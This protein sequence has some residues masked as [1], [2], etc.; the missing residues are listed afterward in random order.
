MTV[1][2]RGLDTGFLPE[3]EVRAIFQSMLTRQP[4][5]EEIAKLA[6]LIETNPSQG[7]VDVIWA[8]LNTQQFLFV[9]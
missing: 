3:D 5:D 1:V 2:G 6:P 7:R 8:L 9:L 4:S